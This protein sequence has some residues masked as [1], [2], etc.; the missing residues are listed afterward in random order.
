[1]SHKRSFRGFQG[2]NADFSNYILPRADFVGS[3]LIG[4]DFDSAIMFG[5]DFTDANLKGANFD[6][7]D[8]EGA[9][10][11]RANL[12]GANFDGSSLEGANF[13]EANL[14]KANFDSICLK[15]V[16]FVGADLTEAKLVNADTSDTIFQPKD[17]KFWK[18]AHKALIAERIRSDSGTSYYYTKANYNYK[19]E[20]KMSQKSETRND[21]S[22]IQR[23]T[24]SY[25]NDIAMMEQMMSAC[26]GDVASIT[27]CI[28][29]IR[30]LKHCKAVALDQIAKKAQGNIAKK[31]QGNSDI[32][33]VLGVFMFCIL[34]IATILLVIQYW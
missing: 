22:E 32:Y 1:M 14:K 25:D 15:N 31:A 33:V 3:S 10:F 34:S 2:F 4:A 20:K 30:D 26:S 6:G 24:E 12:E 28:N 21:E 8:L 5:I 11:I 16:N 17:I 27:H 19:G 29:S 9:I 7:V 13:T 18:S 23:I